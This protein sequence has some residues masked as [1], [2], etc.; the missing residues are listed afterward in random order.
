MRPTTGLTIV[1]AILCGQPSIDA[2]SAA[3]AARM[4]KSSSDNQ[5]KTP[6]GFTVD[7]PKKDW[8]VV[9]GAGSSI[10]VFVH[11]SRQ[12]TV[13]IERTRVEH[14]L[15]PNEITDQTAQLEIEDWQARRPLA[16]GFKHEFVDFG[17]RDIAIDFTQHG[18]QGAERVRMYTLPRGA[19]WYRV[20]CTAA[21]DSF[22]K[23]RDICHRMAQSLTP[24]Q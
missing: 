12:A 5:L 11:K 19:D 24:T 6:L 3:Q 4:G 2:T 17:G 13:A 18:A 7:Y 9:V 23:Y 16:T 21:A 10:V 1:L 14:P 20:I 15:A 22:D 8:Q